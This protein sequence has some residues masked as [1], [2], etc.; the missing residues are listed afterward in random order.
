MLVGDRIVS[1]LRV[2]GIFSGTRRGVGGAGQAIDY[3]ATDLIWVASGL[4]VENW[5][6]EDHETMHRQLAAF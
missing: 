5:H 3:L 4:T 2:T 6:V 1:H